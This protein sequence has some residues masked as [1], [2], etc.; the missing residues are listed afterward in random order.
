MRCS[1]RGMKHVSTACS[2]LLPQV[3][4]A[5]CTV[6]QGSELFPR[7]SGPQQAAPPLISLRCIRESPHAPYTVIQNQHVF[8]SFTATTE[9]VCVCVREKLN[10]QVNGC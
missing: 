5:R 6:A 8:F 10:V 4:Q 7:G 9:C 3:R 1:G 2:S